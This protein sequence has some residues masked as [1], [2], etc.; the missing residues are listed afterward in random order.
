[1]EAAQKQHRSPACS[2]AVMPLGAHFRGYLKATSQAG[3]SSAQC[4]GM[5]E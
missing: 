1:M 3:F 2:A 4:M 5:V